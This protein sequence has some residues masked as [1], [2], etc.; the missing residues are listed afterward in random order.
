MNNILLNKQCKIVNIV[1]TDRGIILTLLYYICKK[2]KILLDKIIII[3]NSRYRKFFKYLF[4]KLKF[5]KFISDTPDNFYFNIR[6]IIK[7]QNIIID[8]LS[9]YDEYIHAKKLKVVPWYD[10]NDV[11]IS[12]EYNNNNSKKLKLKPYL[13]FLNNFKCVR[14]NY[15]KP[16]LTNGNTLIWDVIIEYQILYKYKL[17]NQ[18]INIYDFLNNF[19]KSNYTN[20]II[21]IPKIYYIPL[22]SNNIEINQS[23]G[24][25]PIKNM[26]SEILDKSVGINSIKNMNSETLDQSVE[27]KPIKNIKQGTRNHSVIENNEDDILEFIK[28]I[29][30]QLKSVNDIVSK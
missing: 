19:L 6:T 20:T 28:L 7:K 13:I 2:Y 9:N 15:N 30:L 14:G 8:Y 17:L 21:E 26:N 27:I 5:K 29:T 25:N 18:N 23:V 4:P 24:I 3:N 1:W 22:Q 10:M 11:L 12:Y 16:R